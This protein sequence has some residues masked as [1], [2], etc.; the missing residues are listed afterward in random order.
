MGWLSRLLSGNAEVGWDDLRTLTVDAVAELAH[1][2]AR[3]EVTFPSD[4]EVEI[5]VPD[6]SLAVAR[7]FVEDARFD[8]EV[9]AALAN[10]CDVAPGALPRR[11]YRVSAGEQLRVSITER[12]PRAWELA[13]DGGDASGATLA[14]PVGPSELTFGRGGSAADAR[15]QVDLVVCQGTSFVSRR[16]GMIHRQGHLLEVSALDQGDLLAV[17]R[18]SGEMVRPARTARGRV[19]VREGDVIEL[20]DGKGAA[21]RLV[22]RRATA[23]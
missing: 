3:G 23:G 20:S 5:E 19:A 12:V 18:A 2:G 10:R 6:R 9:G 1:H 13:I 7:G 8:R 11:E 21:V 15:G 22:V 4:L 17:R 16:A 14:V